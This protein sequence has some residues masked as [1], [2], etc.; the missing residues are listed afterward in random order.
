[1]STATNGAAPGKGGTAAAAGHELHLR[2]ALNLIRQKQDAHGR[3]PLEYDYTGKTWVDFGPKNQPNP[4][5]TL[6]ALRVLRA[7]A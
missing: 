4:W 1:M 3:W 6:R 2:D 7:A 5:I